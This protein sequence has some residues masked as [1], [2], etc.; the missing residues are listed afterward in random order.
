MRKDIGFALDTERQHGAPLP[1]T[2]LVDQFYG[3]LQQRGDNMLD[4]STHI[5]LLQNDARE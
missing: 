5:K 3:Q 2:A 1:L 4:T